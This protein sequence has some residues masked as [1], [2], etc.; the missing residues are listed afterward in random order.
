[1]YGSQPFAARGNRLYPYLRAT[2]G[3]PWYPGYKTLTVAPEH[4]VEWADEVA[5]S[6][7]GIIGTLMLLRVPSWDSV[8]RP[9]S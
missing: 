4:F 5:Y 3:A 1:V 2:T 7:G 8:V 6:I 9:W